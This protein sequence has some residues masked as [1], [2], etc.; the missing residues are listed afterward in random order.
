MGRDGARSA[1]SNW[2]PKVIEGGAITRPSWQQI[3]RLVIGR[4]PLNRS[5][6]VHFRIATDDIR[7]GLEANRKQPLLD[8]WTGVVGELPPFPGV[9]RYRADFLDWR[10]SLSDAYA[11]FKGLKRPI[12]EDDHGFDVVAFV[13]KPLKIFVFEPSMGCLIK[14]HSVPSD[15]VLVVYA[16]LDYNT[17]R[18]HRAKPQVGT[19]VAGVV[20]GW[21]FV[22]TDPDGSG[23]PLG[24]KQR[25]RTR[26]W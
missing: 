5:A 12:G 10:T 4:S 25:Y 2:T 13:C 11:C 20:F 17:Q 8:L 24:H 18:S 3:P 14:P 26:L 7:K 22:E 6:P 9:D 19:S 23:L 1:P 16:K 15:L 21:E